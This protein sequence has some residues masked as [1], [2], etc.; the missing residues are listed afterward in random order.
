MGLR[1]GGVGCMQPVLVP[2]HGLCQREGVAVM[3]VGKS[4][5]SSR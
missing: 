5:N 1:P 3:S 2:I 4:R